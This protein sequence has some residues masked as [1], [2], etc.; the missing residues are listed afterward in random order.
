MSSLKRCKKA[1]MIG[2]ASVILAVAVTVVSIAVPVSAATTYKKSGK[3]RVY[4]GK[5]S[6]VYY[7]GKKI[8]TNSRYGIYYNDNFMIPYKNLLVKKGPKIKSSY[9]AVTKTLTLTR[10]NTQIKLTRNSKKI[11][12]NGVRKANLNTAPFN[13]KMEG[14]T[15]MVIP[16]K[17]ICAELGLGYSFESSTRNIYITS[18]VSTQAAVTSSN[19]LTTAASSSN[20]TA[21][22]F[23]NMSTSQ[24]IATMGPIA[25]A[26]YRRTGVLASVTLAQAI[27]ESG[28]GKTTLAQKGNNIFGMKTSLSGNTWEGS[29]WDGKSCVSIVTTEEYSGK[30]VKI[31]AKFRKYNTVA[32]SVADHSAYLS[33]ARNGLRRRYYGL[34]STKSYAQQLK[35]LQ[36]GGYCTWSSYV[37]ELTSLIKKYNLTQYDN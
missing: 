1:L 23:L 4:T 21:A 25:Q 24:F 18:P 35:I 20:L 30:K 32:N 22:S 10:D 27:N 26:D 17:R 11:Y 36:S 2:M 37:N 19:N 9:N 5:K 3:T 16:V 33:N 29:V 14:T 7:D 13:V 31:T 6:A 28:W 12:V 34:T 8:S 15:L